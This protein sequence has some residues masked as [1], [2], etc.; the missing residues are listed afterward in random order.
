MAKTKGEQNFG[1]H[2]PERADDE[3]IIIRTVQ[4]PRHP[5]EGMVVE[6]LENAPLGR[7]RARWTSEYWNAQVYLTAQ[8]ARREW[9]L[10]NDAAARVVKNYGLDTEETLFSLPVRCAVCGGSHAPTPCP[11]TEQADYFYDRASR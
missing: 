1:G 5:A 6:F 7:L 2:Y 8:A 4:S 10:L 11:L 9:V 3:V